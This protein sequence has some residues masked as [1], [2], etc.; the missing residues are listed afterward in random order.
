MSA[1]RM[2]LRCWSR[3]RSC[4]ANGCLIKIPNACR[5]ESQVKWPRNAA[6]ENL[7]SLCFGGRGITHSSIATSPRPQ[8]VARGISPRLAQIRT[9]SATEKTQRKATDPITLMSAERMILRCWSKDC[10]CCAKGCRTQIPN[11]CRWESQAN[12]PYRAPCEPCANP[13]D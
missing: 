3:D 10:P 1:E 8:R 6:R 9:V 4:C 7:R 11:A 5:W 2:I 13:N 12:W